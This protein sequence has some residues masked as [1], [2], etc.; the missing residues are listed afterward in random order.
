MIVKCFIRGP[1]IM[2]LCCCLTLV[3]GQDGALSYGAK[4]GSTFTYFT[5]DFK[6]EGGNPGLQVGGIVNYQLSDAMQITGD[7]DYTQLRGVI[8]GNP[9]TVSG[10]QVVKDNNLTI[11][12][13]EANGLFGYKLPLSLLGEAAP[14]L[15]GGAS[16][17]YNMGTWNHY[18][19]RYIPSSGSE[20]IEVTGKENT[21]DVVD[22]FIASWMV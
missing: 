13:L 7:L 11:H 2:V 18:S 12:A 22:P 17:A 20:A 19:A 1:M 21:G 8:K 6:L 3:Y 5:N 10:Y 16:I 4:V 9:T 15:Q 14:Y